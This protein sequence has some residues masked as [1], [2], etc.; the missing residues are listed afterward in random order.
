VSLADL[1]QHYRLVVCD[2]W[3]CVHNGV[4]VFPEAAAVLLR[5]REQGRIVLLLTNAPRPA[6][7][8]E[9][10]LDQLGLER[11]AF[12]AVITSGDTGLEALRARGEASAGFIGTAA[13]RAILGEAGIRLLSE[14]GGEVVVCTG[15]ADGRR[16]PAEHDAD[17]AAMLAR[18]A[19]LFC[20]NPDR[21]VMR[22]DAL[23]PCA[24]AIADRYEAMGGKV[25]WFGKPYPAVYRRVLAVGSQFAA[26]SI[27]PGEVVAVGDGLKT[28][29]VGAAQAGFDF[30][31]ISHGIEGGRIDERG[32]D[33]VVDEFA[34]GEGLELPRPIAVETSLA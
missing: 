33:A 10:Q 6:F 11:A 4:R 19:T 15:L 13:D 32:L 1:P 31:F 25:E 2:I 20:F 5:W 18:G 9:R 24:G 21:V 17:L 12:D 23:E 14:A 8:V 34:A 7:A 27:E 3:G 22:G 28:D 30:V 26:R 16:E 29:F